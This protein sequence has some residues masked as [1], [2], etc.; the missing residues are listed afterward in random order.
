M[1][2]RERE[3]IEELSFQTLLVFTTEA[4]QNTPC[5]KLASQK[6][7]IMQYH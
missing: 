3:H 2:S 6:C 7:P 5:Y 1:G 4:Y